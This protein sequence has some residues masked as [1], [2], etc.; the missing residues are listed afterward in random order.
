MRWPVHWWTT[1]VMP[2][3][4]YQTVWTRQNKEESPSNALLIKINEILCLFFPIYLLFYRIHTTSHKTRIWQTNV[5]SFGNF[6]MHGENSQVEYTG[7]PN[8]ITDSESKLDL[9][10]SKQNEGEKCQFFYSIF[11]P[12][13]HWTTFITNSISIKLWW[14]FALFSPNAIHIQ[15]CIYTFTYIDWNALEL[16]S[17]SW[18]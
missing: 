12:L 18:C 9:E 3:V 17:M 16:R 1:I 6:A 10:W 4:A 14:S 15:V 11:V 2:N 7:K 8:E 13:H 5:I